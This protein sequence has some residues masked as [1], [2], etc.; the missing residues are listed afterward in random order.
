MN[1]TLIRTIATLVAPTLAMACGIS[2][3]S[4]SEERVAEIGQALTGSAVLTPGNVYA[5][6]H[7]TASSACPAGKTMTGGGFV[8]ENS[9]FMKACGPNKKWWFSEA[10]NPGSASSTVYA[11][12]ECLNAVVGATTAQAEVTI[13]PNASGCA[14]AT[15]PANYNATGGGFSENRVGP[16]SYRSEPSGTTAWIACTYNDTSGPVKFTTYARCVAS[17]AGTVTS[18]TSGATPIGAGQSG[19]ALVSC[20]AGKFPA[21]GGYRHTQGDWTVTSSRA[22]SSYWAVAATNNTSSSGNLYASVKCL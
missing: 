2:S 19:S 17:S 20:P 14:I 12:A 11:E 15:C 9:L 6:E 10:D 5:G 4:E 3:T 21:G 18:A 22:G 13:N 1:R 16:H 7:E 8:N